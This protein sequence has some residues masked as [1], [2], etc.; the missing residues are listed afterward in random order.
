MSSKNIWSIIIGFIL[1]IIVVGLIM[2]LLYWFLWRNNPTGLC[3]GK[4][5]DDGL[6]CDSI[7]TKQDYINVKSFADDN[8][9]IPNG[10]DDV[11][12]VYRFLLALMEKHLTF[13]KINNIGPEY[14]YKEIGITYARMFVYTN[15]EHPNSKDVF[16]ILGSILDYNELKTNGSTK[17]TD[18]FPDGNV[19]FAYLKE[20]YDKIKSIL[21][22][23]YPDSVTNLY[24]VTIDDSGSI[25]QQFRHDFQSQNSIQLN[26]GEIAT[27]HGTPVADNNL[28]VAT[29]S[30]DKYVNVISDNLSQNINKLSEP[31]DPNYLCLMD[32]HRTP[33]W[34]LFFR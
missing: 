21:Q 4:M 11:N 9:N 8:T 28:Y 32:Y 23:N 6:C 16:L 14:D 22:P 29:T 13:E 19:T 10:M 33:Y 24:V 5:K 25:G 18:A 26:L 15:S 30:K 12:N 27:I 34:A 7:F 17:P 3:Y 20:K 1:F 2:F 31:D